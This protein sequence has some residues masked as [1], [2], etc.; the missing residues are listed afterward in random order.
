LTNIQKRKEINL[1]EGKM[2]DAFNKKLINTV[3]GAGLKKNNILRSNNK[4]NNFKKDGLEIDSSKI[5][6]NSKLSWCGKLI[7]GDVEHSWRFLLFSLFSFVLIFVFVQ[8]VLAL[9]ITPGRNTLDYSPG[10]VET[11]QFEIV[12]GQGEDIDVVIL[13]QGELNASISVSEVSF[14]MSG[15]E[16]S[17]K[18]TYTLTMPS[19]LKPGLHTAE[20]VALQLPGKSKEGGT[21]IGA[22]VG[23]TT[24]VHVHVPYPGKYLEA[25]FDVTPSSDGGI[26]FILP[27]ISRGELGIV[28]AK[29]VIDIY[30]S[31]NEKIDTI[32]TD[33]IEIKSLDR[34]EL[35]ALW[36]P[37][38][39]PPGRYKAVATVI[40]DE[41]TVSVEKEF[42]IGEQV[43]EIKISLLEG[44]PNLRFW[45]R[46][47][48][49]R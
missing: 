39:A 41:E 47:S 16:A 17:K 30:T 21:F 15:N 45:L 46:I 32:T 2:A 44:L 49:A 33:E 29:A 14:K 34:R 31:L 36:K 18:L 19:G 25:S 11:Y 10:K 37:Q 40:Y 42:S 35:T 28:R 4:I 26:R 38:S 8:N 6:E 23:V 48:G 13:V 24:Q 5:N 7:S 20:I 43:L 22:S 1:L 3:G 12:N 9:G 27:L